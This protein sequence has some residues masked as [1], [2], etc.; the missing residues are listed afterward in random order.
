[1]SEHERI[2][3]RAGAAEVG[4]RLDRFVAGQ[5]PDRSRSWAKDLVIRGY[6]E[7][8]GRREAPQFRLDA[9]DLVTITVVPRR[10]L[11]GEHTPAPELRVLFEDEAILVIDKAAGHVV[12]PGGN[13]RDTT[14]ADAAAAHCGHDLP[15]PS[16]A[17]RGG[18]VHR[19]DKDTSGVMV[20]AKTEAALRA[21]QAEFKERRVEKEYRA[22][23][24]GEPR[25]LS[26]WIDTRIARDPRHPERM[27]TVRED[28]RDALSYYETLRVFDGHAELMC[29]PK[30]GRTHQ[31]RVH[32]SSIGLPLVGD[33][34]YRPRA[35]Q[36]LALPAGAPDPGRH[37]LHARRLAFAHPSSSTEVAFEAELPGDMVDLLAWLE[38]E[39]PRGG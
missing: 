9:G 35:Q 6:V 10:E 18:I 38:R 21:L 30:T 39:R 16:G 37:C 27:K 1:M 36:G 33:V 4:W 8:A 12:H 22:I 24:F 19:L 32:L 25:F 13:A 34:L 11:A 5:L 26:D 20:L 2:E 23:V 14:V 31:I 7:V 15:D 3:R 29:R 17:G 28:G